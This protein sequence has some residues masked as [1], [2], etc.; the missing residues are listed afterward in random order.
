[1]LLAYTQCKLFHMLMLSYYSKQNS[2]L[3]SFQINLK[4]V[5]QGAVY[6]IGSAEATKINIG[7]LNLYKLT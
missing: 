6:V 5:G 7:D 3:W 2:T 1:M 4:T